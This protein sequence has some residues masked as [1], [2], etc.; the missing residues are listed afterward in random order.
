MQEELI[1]FPPRS[2]KSRKARWSK[3]LVV[4]SLVVFLI[5]C[6]MPIVRIAVIDLGSVHVYPHS[7][8]FSGV[9]IGCVALV[10]L[11]NLTAALLGV[12]AIVDIGRTGFRTIGKPESMV[13]VAGA[14][15]VAGIIIAIVVAGIPFVRKAQ[16]SARHAQCRC[17]MKQFG[18]AFHNYHTTYGSFPPSAICDADGKPLLSWR[19]SLLPYLEGH[20]LYS[21]FRLD[22]PWDS[23][24]NLPLAEQ[25]PEVFRCPS[26]ST[27]KP[28]ASSYVIVEGAGT[29]FPPGGTVRIEDVT[30]G[31]SKTIMAAE[32]VGSA[33]PWTKPDNLVFDDRFNGQ[34][35]FSSGHT[36]GW[37]A[38]WGD[39][40][41]HFFRHSVPADTI[42]SLLTI[43][44]GE[45]IDMTKF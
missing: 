38:L 25:I 3:R 35:A 32:A 14:V 30:D 42:R 10:V 41:V 45:Q 43:D 31:T 15:A 26:D 17:Y 23:P 6:L 18:V 9:L 12:L 2:N 21:Q 22:E 29:I 5:P 33:S 16:E 11:M 8:L 36:G 1:K 27:S 19:V 4:W 40:S 13:G 24:H 39:G 37:M 44:G 7:E 28:N 34:T 20:E